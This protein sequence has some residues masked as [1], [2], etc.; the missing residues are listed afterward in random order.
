MKRLID[1][2][3][4]TPSVEQLFRPPNRQL[5]QDVPFA[6]LVYDTDILYPFICFDRKK[7]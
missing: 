5:I 6:Q 7:Y 2:A 4:V 3:F 1:K